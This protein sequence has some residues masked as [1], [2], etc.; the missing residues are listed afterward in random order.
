MTRESRCRQVSSRRQLGVDFEFQMFF[1]R[2]GSADSFWIGSQLFC[3]PFRE[4]SYTAHFPPPF[5]PPRHSAVTPH[6]QGKIKETAPHPPREARAVRCYTQVRR[7]TLVTREVRP[8]LF[9]R[10]HTVAQ[11]CADRVARSVSLT[12]GLRYALG[13][14]GLGAGRSS[15]RLWV[16]D[17]FRGRFGA[18]SFAAD[19]HASCLLVE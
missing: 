12:A 5:P 4:T 14:P 2:R 11:P 7:Y 13:A 19:L 6:P 8:Q 17:V 15:L 18:A 16:D 3:R 9:L 1:S 10:R